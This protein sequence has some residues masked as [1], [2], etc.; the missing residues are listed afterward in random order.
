MERSTFLDLAC[1]NWEEKNSTAKRKEV[2]SSSSGNLQIRWGEDQAHGRYAVFFTQPL[3]KLNDE[4][5]FELREKLS[6]ELHHFLFE[7]VRNCETE[8]KSLLVAGLG[9]PKMTADALGAEVCDRMIVTGGMEET[10]S[11]ISLS[12]VSLGVLGTTGIESFEHLDAL[13]RYLRPSVVLAVDALSA[14]SQA[15]V[16]A[17]IQISTGGISPG[18]GV[19]NSQKTLSQK[20]LGVPVV[21]LG[22][23]TVVRS[24]VIIR[25]AMEKLGVKASKEEAI[26][27]QDSFFL[28]PKECD[29]ILRNAALLL[30]SAIHRACEFSFL[31]SHTVR[32]D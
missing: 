17:T 15:R 4:S 12:A 13:C 10:S 22:V 20:T 25:E 5:F 23:P 9:N 19:G 3:W 21:S 31:S 7:N 24:S 16:G 11:E 14:K 6:E 26:F 1:E 32:E 28:M 30:S 18:A 8:K 29:L 2:W 27:A